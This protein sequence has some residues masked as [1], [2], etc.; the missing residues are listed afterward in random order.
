MKISFSL[1]DN[2]CTP[3]RQTSGASGY[4]CVARKDTLLPP[5]IPT[6]VPLGFRLALPPGYEA[7][8]RPRSG[9]SLGGIVVIPG[10]VDSDYRGE[11]CAIIVNM[12][13]GMRGVNRGDRCCQMVIARVPEV[14]LAMG[15]LDETERG[16]GGFGSTG[17]A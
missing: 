9:L 6:K 17:G 5:G 15:D 1:D 4:D 3:T 13:E 14:E 11:V 7:Q 16:D 2:T 8:I 10:T 12:N